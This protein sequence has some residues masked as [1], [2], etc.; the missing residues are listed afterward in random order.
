MFEILGG[1]FIRIKIYYGYMEVPKVPQVLEIIE[2]LGFVFKPKETTYLLG[3]ETIISTKKYPRM[4][5]WREKLF[6]SLSK[7][8]RSAT[9]YYG[10]FFHTINAFV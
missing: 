8:A 3:R 5:L 2:E 10:N 4:A 6:A 9:A 1:G 7:N